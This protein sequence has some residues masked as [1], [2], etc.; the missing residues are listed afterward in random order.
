[1]RRTGFT[2]IEL[3]VVLALAAV[4]IGVGGGYLIGFL[5][6]ASARSA[7]QV[8]ARD[9]SQAR[10]FASRSREA[11]TV[12]F[13]E[14][15]LLYRVESAAGRVLAVR[16]F[17]EDQDVV[18]SRVDLELTGDS[19]LFSP[20]GLAVLPSGVGAAVFVA[21]EDIYEVRFNGTG[22]SRLGTR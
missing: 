13:F 22:Q 20:Q 21:G 7:A 1:M 19:V 15:S 11:V 12:R 2:L 8:F 9:L 3:T 14:D 10:S 6:K 5:G 16:R 18:L 17:D 4:T